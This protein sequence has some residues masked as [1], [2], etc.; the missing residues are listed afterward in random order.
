MDKNQKLQLKH[1]NFVYNK[2]NSVDAYIESWAD[3]H[4]IKNIFTDE[5][6][7]SSKT[8]GRFTHEPQP[9]SFVE[10]YN[11]KNAKYSEDGTSVVFRLVQNRE[12]SPEIYEKYVTFA[13]KNYYDTCNMD[14]Q[15]CFAN[16]EYVNVGQIKTLCK[17]LSSQLTS[18]PDTF[19]KNTIEMAI[20]AEQRRK[21]NEELL[22][23]T[24]NHRYDDKDFGHN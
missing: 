1:V 14:C 4:K 8:N 19:A 18:D 7:E 23:Q 22:E 16:N 20:L 5:I 9:V 24:K 15:Q 10:K 3:N 6:I 11:L 21:N 17:G 2:D 13:K 12:I